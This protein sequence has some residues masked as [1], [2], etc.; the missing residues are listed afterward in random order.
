LSAEYLGLPEQLQAII[1]HDI[2]GER[3]GGLM[4]RAAAA[5]RARTLIVVA[6]E[7]H[8]VKPGPALK[9]AQLLR[10]PTL[11]LLGECGHLA[12][13]CQKDMLDSAGPRFRDE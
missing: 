2:S 7:D 9:F 12:I 1:A 3:F 8:M 10:G 4:E 11:V 6:Q 5:V 13:L